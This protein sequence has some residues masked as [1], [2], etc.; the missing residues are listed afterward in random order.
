MRN[1]H[2]EA[3]KVIMDTAASLTMTAMGSGTLVDIYNYS[4]KFLSR[5]ESGPPCLKFVQS[6]AGKVCIEL[7]GIYREAHAQVRR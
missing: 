7:H 1:T 6:D 2:N 4:I 3:H 5:S